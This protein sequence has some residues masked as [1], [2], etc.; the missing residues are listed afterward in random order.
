MCVLDIMFY[1]SF[2]KMIC[3]KRF[4]VE[5]YNLM[6]NIVMEIKYYVII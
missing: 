5:I 2:V 4:F 1:G 6:R 3:I